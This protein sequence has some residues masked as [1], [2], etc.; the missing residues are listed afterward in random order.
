[1]SVRIP[2]PGNQ[3]FSASIDPL[4]IFRYLNRSALGNYRNRI[5]FDDDGLIRKLG[6]AVD[7]D[8][9]YIVNCQRFRLL[10]IQAGREGCGEPQ[11]G[12]N[13]ENRNPWAQD[14]SSRNRG[15]CDPRHSH[16]RIRCA[17]RRQFLF[18]R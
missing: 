11:Q 10:R 6:A 5:A 9:G 15:Y 1:M 12:G 8:H 3:E 14:F 2:K 17:V 4:R 18:F 7:I 13:C 16:R